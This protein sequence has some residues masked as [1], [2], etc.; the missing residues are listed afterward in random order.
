MGSREKL[1]INDRQKGRRVLLTLA[2]LNNGLSYEQIQSRLSNK[3]DR[4]FNDF[5]EECSVSSV[6]RVISQ[7][8]LG[9]YHIN[10]I[11]DIPKYSDKDRIEK[12]DLEIITD[13]PSLG[14]IGIQIKSSIT[15]ISKFYRHL[16]H[17]LDD[18]KRIAVER[19]IIVLNGS[20]DDF[21]IKKN[22]L[23]QFK[24]I[25]EYFKPKSIN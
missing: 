4:Y 5:R 22:F 2:G 12:H 11:I 7:L 20:L 23:D 10:D 18:A 9:K 19:K 25:C 1:F 21:I 3:Q 14:I 13:D 24:N 17:N 16:D 15:G 6:R 8:S